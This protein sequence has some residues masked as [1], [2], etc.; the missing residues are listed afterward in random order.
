[1]LY[2]LII[3]TV[4]KLKTLKFYLFRN[5]LKIFNIQTMFITDHHQIF[6]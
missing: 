3:K 2:L 6:L 1:M 4:N 5:Y